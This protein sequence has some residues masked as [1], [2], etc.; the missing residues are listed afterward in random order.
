MNLSRSSTGI[1]FPIYYRTLS[2]TSNENLG[3]IF[4]IFTMKTA[5]DRYLT[6]ELRTCELWQIL[7][8]GSGKILF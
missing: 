4:F 7:I 5:L 8:L 6:L 2:K 3:K 1:L